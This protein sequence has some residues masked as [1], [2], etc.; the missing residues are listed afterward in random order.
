MDHTDDAI[1]QSDALVL[2]GITGDLARKKIFPALYG[3]A[4]RGSLN[5]PVVGVA[6]PDWTV[7]QLRRRVTD[8][9]KA[10][11]KIEDQAA[12]DRLL[13]LLGYVS[14][15]YHDPATFDAPKQ[16]L[17]EARHPAHYLT[18]PPALFET[19]VGG[20]DAIA[21]AARVKRPGKE[22]TGEQRELYLL[23]EQSEEESPYERLLGDA[24]AGEGALFARRI[25]STPA[26]RW[27]ILSWRSITGP[28]R[29]NP[30]VGAPKAADVLIGADGNWHNPKLVKEKE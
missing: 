20:L 15:D 10:T 22:F 2:F 25:V 14:G 4:K 8:A 16:A 11:G 23:D 26:G 18:I 13:S 28:W 1:R 17:G 5:V 7:A 24:M 27:S 29:K 3:M 6:A 30:V 21:L 12:L 19:V 9:I